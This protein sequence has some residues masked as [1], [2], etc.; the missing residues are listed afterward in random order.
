MQYSR[1][2]C[3]RLQVEERVLSQAG[4]QTQLFGVGALD[5][6]EETVTCDLSTGGVPEHHSTVLGHVGEVDV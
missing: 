1:V 6:E 3:V 4:G 2:L 5:G